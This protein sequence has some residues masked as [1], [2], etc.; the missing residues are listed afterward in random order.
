MAELEI[1][2]PRFATPPSGPRKFTPLAAQII[3]TQEMKRELF[4]DPL[5]TMQEAKTAL[6]M[7]YSTLRKLIAAGKIRSWRPS[8][9]GHHR[10]RASEIR[11]YLAQG[12]QA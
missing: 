2:T 3:K 6:S 10:V 8:P 1:R 9:K 4:S 12:E 5:L 7:S 11:K